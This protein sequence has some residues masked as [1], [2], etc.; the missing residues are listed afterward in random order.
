VGHG[1]WELEGVAVNT[2]CLAAAGDS[3]AARRLTPG[4]RHRVSLPFSF[5]FLNRQ[6]H[7]SLVLAAFSRCSQTPRFP[8]SWHSCQILYI[9]NTLDII[10][11]K[12]KNKSN[13]VGALEVSWPWFMAAFTGV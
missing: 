3:F 11:N 13:F 2:P 8:P 1:T 12:K 10:Q 4:H 7:H 5:P 9:T 6:L